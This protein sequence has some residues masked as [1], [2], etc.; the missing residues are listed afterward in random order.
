MNAEFIV[1]TF[2]VVDKTMQ[3][4]GHQDDGRAKASDA[5]VVTVAVVA[6]R[7]FQNHLERALQ[8]MHVGHYLS[9]PLSVSRCNRL[10]WLVY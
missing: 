8:V 10:C 5:E 4:L 9:G 1:T 3:V 6:A 2:V 7:Y